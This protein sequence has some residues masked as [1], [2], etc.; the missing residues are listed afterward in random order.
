[1][2]REGVRTYNIK[3]FT[4]HHNTVDEGVLQLVDRTDQRAAQARWGKK[5]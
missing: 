2:Q 5:P 4:W 3:G 1:M